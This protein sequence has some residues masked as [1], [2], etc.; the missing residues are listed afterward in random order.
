M[1][2]CDAAPQIV[3][4]AQAKLLAQFSAKYDIIAVLG[5]CDTFVEQWLTNA[6]FEFNHFKIQKHNVHSHVVVF[7]SWLSFAEK[8]HL[9]E[10]LEACEDWF[11]R[12]VPRFNLFNKAVCSTVDTQAL[13]S[14]FSKDSLVAS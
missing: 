4:I 2:L 8:A 10:S 9:S 5:D 3:S 6:C 1:Y 12:T 11:V 7:Q 14:L 13:L